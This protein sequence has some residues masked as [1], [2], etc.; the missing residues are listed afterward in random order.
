MGAIFHNYSDKGMIKNSV[1]GGAVPVSTDLFSGWFMFNQVQ[2]DYLTIIT[3]VSI[4]N[5]DVVQFFLSFDDFIHHYY[6]GKGV[7]QMR[8]SGM[9]FT[10]CGGFFTNAG[11]V[12]AAG[13]MP[14]LG[15]F[16]KVL[17]EKRGTVVTIST[18]GG[19]WF[20]GVLTDCTVTFVSEPETMASFTINLGMIDHSLI[21]PG[22]K[23]GCS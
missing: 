3:E 1:G 8:I 23:G 14:G 17:G 15:H 22:F 6:F 16:Y 12:N 20:K 11:V 10:D 19:M 4:T 21:N 5:N 13:G 9:F 2:A 18:D 7:G